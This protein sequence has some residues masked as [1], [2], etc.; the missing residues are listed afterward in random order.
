MMFADIVK[1][2][3]KFQHTIRMWTM[4]RNRLEHNFTI[5]DLEIPLAVT[6]LVKRLVKYGKYDLIL[7]IIYLLF[8]LFSL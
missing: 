1:L 3:P 2:K 8:E 4:F 6:A 5:E 7:V